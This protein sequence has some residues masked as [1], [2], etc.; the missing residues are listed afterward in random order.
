MGWREKGMG[1]S[2]LTGLRA[3]VRTLLDRR[4]H[5]M[6]PAYSAA[7]CLGLLTSAAGCASRPALAAADMPTMPSR[8]E[9]SATPT[10]RSQKPDGD[11]A[12]PSTLKGL[13]QI[14][15]Q[16]LPGVKESQMAAGIRA[17]V[18]NR[19]ILDEEVREVAYPFLMATMQVPE[20]ARTRQQQEILQRELQRLIEREVI[21]ADAMALL[22]K[23]GSKKRYLDKLREA[24]AKEF[25]KQVRSM[26]ERANCKTDEELKAALRAQGL[27]LDGIRRQAE[28]NFMAA[29]YMRSRIFPAIDRI[30]HEEIREYYEK[31]PA[32][33]EVADGVKWLDIFLDV[34][35]YPSRQAAHAMADQLVARARSGEDFKKLALQ[36]DNG[37]S[38]YRDGEGYGRRRGEI[39]PPEAEPILFQMK[40]GEVGPIIEQANGFHV[41]KLVKR[42]YAGRRPFDEDT[43]RAIRVKL[44]NETFEREYKRILTELK[45]KASIEIAATP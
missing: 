6:H 35:K 34:H 16:E 8:T 36:Y 37:D 39:R 40:D 2:V 31:H 19:P 1:R 23:P 10:A 17:T 32:E 14:N 15:Y 5:R 4:P 3:A 18:N 13:L 7:A 12:A 38:S 22:D 44:Q 20:P 27:S 42:D 28:R 26:R 43:Q 21:L 11:G 24:A 29:E 9:I 25:E 45:R 33:F 41:F 30:G